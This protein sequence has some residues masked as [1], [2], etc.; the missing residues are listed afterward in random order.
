[1]PFK[2]VLNA[3][4]APFA[5]A[6]TQYANF[7]FYNL[8]R[9]AIE[10]SL[11]KTGYQLQTDLVYGP[12]QRHRLDMYWTEQPRA[13]Q[14]LLVFVHGGAWSEGDKSDYTFLGES[15]A[16]EGFNVAVIN[17]RLAPEYIFPS[18]VNDLVLALN[19]L[20]QQAQIATQHIVL[21]GHSAGAFN[22][23]SALYT[24]QNEAL[25]CQ[26]NIRAVIGLAGP[27]HFDYKDDPLCANALI[28]N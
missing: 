17:Y 9:Y 16:K 26:Q 24:A 23:M 6:R 10:Y 22:V 15:F 2:S 3:A 14:P 20:D 13:G 8:G 25:A 1:M 21:L 4:R 19:F 11:T 12:H 7:K 5:L 27:Y 28:N 18:S